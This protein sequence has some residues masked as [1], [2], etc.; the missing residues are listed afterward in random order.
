MAKVVSTWSAAEGAGGGLVPVRVHVLLAQGESGI[1]MARPLRNFKPARIAWALEASGVALPQGRLVVDMSPGGDPYHD[2][3]GAHLAVAAAV[4]ALSGRFDEGFLDKS[5]FTGDLLVTGEVQSS[6]SWRDVCAA[7]ERVRAEPVLAASLSD[8]PRAL[9]IDR[10]PSAREAFES[11][12][13][14]A[15]GNAGPAP[16]PRARG[17]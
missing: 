13:P 9:G 15:R 7:A 4:M 14:A 17:M 2:M 11:S 10:A 8:L 6:F 16:S 3:E 5:M 12:L 1:S